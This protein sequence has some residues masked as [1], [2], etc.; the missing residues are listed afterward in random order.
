MKYITI[1]LFK[2][3]PP[4]LPPDPTR[5]LADMQYDVCVRPQAGYCA[6]RW[7]QTPGLAQGFTL[8]GDPQATDPSLL[9]EA[10]GGDFCDFLVLV[11]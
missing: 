11:I 5:Q 10:V 9:G 7:A 2:S 3:I 1:E 4:S 6:V 8:S